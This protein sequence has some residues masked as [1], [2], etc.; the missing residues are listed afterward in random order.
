MRQRIIGLCA[1]L[2]ATL[3]VSEGVFAQG[4]PPPPT[5]PQAVLD[6]EA[7]KDAAYNAA[8][9]QES[10]ALDGSF[11]AAAKKVAALAAYPGCTDPFKKLEGNGK[12]NLGNLSV[13]S[14]ENQQDFGNNQMAFGD[15][16]EAEGDAAKQAADWSLA[17][18]EY[19]TA[20]DYYDEGKDDYVT[21]LV[22]FADAYNEYE[23][24]RVLYVQGTP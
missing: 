8:L 23:N 22:F 14:A 20:A 2:L 10:D 7:A 13:V 5:I 19:N 12:M 18:S 15:E 11:D 4:P 24:A 21:A 16:H 9:S 3:I 6:A 17:I 1:L